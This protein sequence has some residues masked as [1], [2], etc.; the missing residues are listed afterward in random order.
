MIR[1]VLKM[2]A[3]ICEIII[4]I[5]LGITS[6]QEFMSDFLHH[7]ARSKLHT[8]SWGHSRSNLTVNSLWSLIKNTGLF[9]CT[10]FF[11]TVYRFMSVYGLTWIINRFRKVPIPYNDQFI[12]SLSGLRKDSMQK[13]SLELKK[14]V[15]LDGF[16]WI[17]KG[18]N[19]IFS[20]ETGSTTITASNS[21]NAFRLYCCYPIHFFC[22]RLDFW[23]PGVSINDF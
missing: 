5:L 22:S 21:S 17:L 23:I 7:W 14:V 19:S 4:F 12:M 3:I 18:R 8:V 2:C 13:K 11:M 1:Y 16:Y 9:L 6:V 15:E 20:D 10:L